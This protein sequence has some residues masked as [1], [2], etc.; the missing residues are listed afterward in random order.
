M[1]CA[2]LAA[3]ACN[4]ED[5]YMAKIDELEVLKEAVESIENAV[6]DINVKTMSLR[7]FTYMAPTHSDHFDVILC[8]TARISAEL[9]KL[10]HVIRSLTDTNCEGSDVSGF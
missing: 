4:R 2:V 1:G 9:E 3:D 6:H 5:V 10:Q 7:R 8:D